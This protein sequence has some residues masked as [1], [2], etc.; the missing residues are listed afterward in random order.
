MFK[1]D[2]SLLYYKL[3][4][5]LFAAL[6]IFV[7][8]MSSVSPPSLGVTW[9]DKIYHFGEYFVYGLLIFHAFPNVHKSP[10]RKS[11]YAL[12]FL[13]G[14]AYGAIDE[15]VQYY[16]PNRD[17]SPYDWMADAIGYVAA[18][19]VFLLARDWWGRRERARS[20]SAGRSG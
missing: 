19:I 4:P 12:L 18:G 11:L 13:F 7:S 3:P 10:K 1:F 16:I 8:T 2:K 20:I 5:V 14:L 6:I 15:R 9:T 17:S